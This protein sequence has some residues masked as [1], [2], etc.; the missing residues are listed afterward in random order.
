[1]NRKHLLLLYIL[2]ATT[3]FAQTDTSRWIRAFP[4]TSYIVE[5]NDSVKLVQLYLPGGP[6]L[7]DKQVGLLR[8]VYKDDPA[9]TVT[10]GTGLCHLIKGDYYYF[11]INIR[12]SGK[13]PKENDLLYTILEWP[14]VYK[15]QLLRLASHFI[16]LQNV[17]DTPF[18]DR[19][20]IFDKWNEDDE[21]KVMDSIVQDIRFT[22]EYFTKNDP[23]M[24]QLI[25]TGAYKGKMILAVMTTCRKEDV[26][27]FFDYMLV[28]PRLYA[29][30][31]WKLSEIFATWLNSGAPTVIK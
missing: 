3:C 6:V 11:S 21:K 2:V 4:V 16:G 12:E 19:Y 22:G 28:R 17:Y 9:D 13:L 7:K 25:S 29:G 24:N 30:H 26:V 20:T 10:I 14:V 1:M 31:A 27:S 18:Y 15:G 23:S 8:R 5:L